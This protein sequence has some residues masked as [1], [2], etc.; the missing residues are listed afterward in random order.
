VNV[1]DALAGVDTYNV[2][3]IFFSRDTLYNLVQ[4]TRTNMT[5][6]AHDNSRGLVL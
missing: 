4:N 2:M 5:L 6:Q 1:W 3:Y